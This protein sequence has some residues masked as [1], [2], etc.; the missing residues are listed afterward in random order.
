M[1]NKGYWAPIFSPNPINNQKKPAK[2]CSAGFYIN[3]QLAVNK[4]Y[5]F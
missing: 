3:S 4:E 1:Q 5:S 2:Q